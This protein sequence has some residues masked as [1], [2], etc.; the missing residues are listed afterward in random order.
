MPLRAGH[1]FAIEPLMMRDFFLLL[2]EFFLFWGGC[3]LRAGHVFTIEPM[4]NEGQAQVCGSLSLVI[5]YLSLFSYLLSLGRASTVFSL[6][7]SLF[8][9]SI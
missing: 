6:A 8:W 2:F 1:A 7:L 4:I 3:L 9:R 5:F